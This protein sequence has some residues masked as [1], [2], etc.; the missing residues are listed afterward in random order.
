MHGGVSEWVEDCYN[1]KYDG[2]PTDGSAWT[3]HD[4]CAFRVVRGGSSQDIPERIRSASRTGFPNNFELYELGFRVA[5]TLN[6]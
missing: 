1:D 6:R 3:A 2:A 5:R 4:N